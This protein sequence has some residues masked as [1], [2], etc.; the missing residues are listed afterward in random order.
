MKKFKV[1]LGTCGG[2]A[3]VSS[4]INAN[5][6]REAVIKF[7]QSTEEEVTEENI[8]SYLPR[9]FEHIP[10]PRKKTVEKEG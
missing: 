6:K 2:R 5:D 1:G 3:I 9:T 8:N 4:V 7:L 10:K